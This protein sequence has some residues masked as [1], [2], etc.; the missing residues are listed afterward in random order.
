MDITRSVMTTV[1]ALPTSALSAVRPP[2]QSAGAAQLSRAVRR[3]GCVPL[4]PLP[5]FQTRPTW[6]GE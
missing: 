6:A 4:L 3:P 1:E 5:R 2:G